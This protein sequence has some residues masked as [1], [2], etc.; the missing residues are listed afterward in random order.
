MNFPERVA[1]VY[2]DIREVEA[3]AAVSLVSAKEAEGVFTITDVS[4]RVPPG[5]EILPTTGS[6][7]VLA[8]PLAGNYN[9]QQVRPNR[10][11]SRYVVRRVS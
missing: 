8:G 4:V 6:L 7:R 3:P 9:V 10:H 2:S 11:H 1:L 5:Y